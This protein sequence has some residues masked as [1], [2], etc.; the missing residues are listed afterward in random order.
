MYIES[1]NDHLHWFCN[2]L[3]LEMGLPTYGEWDKQDLRKK[4]FIVISFSRIKV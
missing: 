3:W 1:H 2:H 4:K